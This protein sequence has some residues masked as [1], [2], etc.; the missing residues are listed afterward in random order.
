MTNRILR[1]FQQPVGVYHGSVFYQLS[2][3]VGPV[4]LTLDSAGNLYVGQYDLKESSSEGSVYVISPAG[5]LL[6]TIATSG[7]EISG[8]AISTSPNG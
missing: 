1:F 8:L 4:A 6:K 2:G 3:G 5:K 7:S